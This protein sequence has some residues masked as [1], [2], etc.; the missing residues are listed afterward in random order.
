MARVVDIARID[1]RANHLPRVA[2]VLMR[3]GVRIGAG[4]RGHA[5]AYARARLS[6]TTL[7]ILGKG[8]D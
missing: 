2:R 8:R 1:M 3:A 5:H 4:E 6:L 7:S